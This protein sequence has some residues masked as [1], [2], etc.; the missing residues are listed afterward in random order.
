MKSFGI[1]CFHFSIKNGDSKTISIKDY[2][3]EVTRT[4]ESLT[5]VTEVRCSYDESTSNLEID[6][7]S[8]N[9]R[10]KDSDDCYPQILFFDLSF[11]I[12]IPSRIQANLIETHEEYIDTG[13]ENFRVR[14]LHDW[15][16]PLSY[17]EPIGAGLDSKPSTG[18]QVVRNYLRREIEKVETFLIPDFLGPSPFHADIYLV[19]DKNKVQ[20]SENIFEAQINHNPG[21]DQIIFSCSADEFTS[22]EQALEELYEKLTQE[23]AFFYYL[24]LKESRKMH[25]WHEIQE[26][27]HSI[28]SFEDESSKK[29]IKDRFH[30]KPKL[31]RKAFKNIGLLKGKNI[32]DK[33][34]IE[35]NYNSIYLS[36]KHQTYLKTF[37]DQEIS[38]HLTYPIEE[39]S[40]LLRYFDQKTSKAFELT[41]L[42]ISSILGGI[43]GSIITVSFS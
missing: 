23:I 3:E 1:G 17:V 12:Y 9:P 25:R 19:F 2:I 30:L 35:Q 13:S 21:Y 16:G 11:C 38:E 27:L 33:S 6:I 20:S 41:T 7:S 32:F 22:E 29:S 4:L 39:T 37:I 42:I 14:I 5:T 18:V 8:P 40:E 34:T 36:D 26:T 15:H 24:N 10:L 31:F 28:L 43:V